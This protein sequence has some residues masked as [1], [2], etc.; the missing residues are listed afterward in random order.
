MNVPLRGGSLGP[1]SAPAPLLMLG[2]PKGS[3][4][5]S[6]KSLFA[7][8]GWK[9]TSSSRSYTPSIDDPELDGRFVRAQEVSR[10][11]EHGFFDCG[12]TGYDWI[13]ENES[14]VVEVCDLIYSKASVQ[15]SRWVLCVPEASSIKRP[16]DLAGKRIATE[17]VNTVRRYFAEKKISVA[18][19]FSWGATE[20]K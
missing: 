19:E 12:L 18:V 20:V 10:Y 6:T 13:K 17:L 14:D 7:K 3:L 1:V 9:I 15:K 5:E 4:E 11:V 16:E 8:A 2:L